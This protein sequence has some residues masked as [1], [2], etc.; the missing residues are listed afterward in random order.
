MADTVFI[1]MKVKRTTEGVE[2]YAKSEKIAAYLQK[3]VE[4]GVLTQKSSGQICFN[5]ST[6]NIN[7]VFKYDSGLEHNLNSGSNTP[8]LGWMFHK[9]LATGHTHTMAVMVNKDMLQQYLN[10]SKIFL[11]DLFH[12]CMEEVNLELV[13]S[14]RELLKVS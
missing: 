1:E 10:N 11:V 12:S 2:L 5:S 13:I 8:N 7:R 4:K 9:D 14:T 6:T 3:L